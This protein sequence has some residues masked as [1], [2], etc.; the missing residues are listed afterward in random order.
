MRNHF[1]LLLVLASLLAF[2]QK[3]AEGEPS[4][5]ILENR[6]P[7]QAAPVERVAW[8]EKV[9]SYLKELE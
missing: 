4:S 6:S 7:A 5:P 2:V 1:F 9:V 3:F 8:V